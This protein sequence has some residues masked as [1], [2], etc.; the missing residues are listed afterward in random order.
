MTRRLLVIAHGRTGGGADP[1]FGDPGPL[2]A[3]AEIAR[4]KGRIQRWVAGPE[5]ACRQTAEL[6]G[7]S[8]T[9]L[10]DLAAPDPGSWRGRTVGE[11]AAED[12]AGLQAWLTDPD[13]TPPGGESLRQALARLGR[14]I[15]DEEWPDGRSIAVVTPAA[16]RLSAIHTV[17]GPP[18][19]AF[20][21]D[22][23]FGGRFELS[24]GNRGWRLL[25]G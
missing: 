10:P 6:L 11:I 3:G 12:P 16:A 23:R 24:G 14:V 2:A 15:D 21:L 17:G 19:L 9:V 8:P 13:A 20:R 22:V 7:G 1:L 4:P 18:E 5:Q 25:V